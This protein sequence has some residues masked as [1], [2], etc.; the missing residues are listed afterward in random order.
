MSK[1][2]ATDTDVD[3]V[4]VDFYDGVSGADIILNSFACDGSYRWSKV[5]GGNNYELINELQIDAQDNIY[6][7]GQLTQV[8]VNTLNKT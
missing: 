3:G 4:V 8:A 1:I 5:I 7:A 6:V 2:T